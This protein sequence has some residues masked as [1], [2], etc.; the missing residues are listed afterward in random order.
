MASTMLFALFLLSVLTFYPPSITAQVTD[1][2]GNVVRNGGSFYIRPHI[3]SLG[4][5]I[6]RIKTGNETSRLSVV[7]SPFET[8]PG[9]PL[10]ITSP[11]RVQFI[12]EGPVF[13]DFVNDPLGVNS[14]EWKAVEVLSEGTLVKVGYQNSLKG[15]F[16]IERA[17]SA[18]TYK[19]LFCT[20]GGSLCGNVAIVNDE[21]G[22]RLLAVNQKTP[23]QFILTP[24]PST[25]LLGLNEPLSMKTR[26]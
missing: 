15:S 26:A 14:L 19:L 4:G 7:Q 24:L 12:P 6:R 8:D 10:K 13:I 25:S 9:L 22:N 1:G 3:F 18:N 11:Y 20:L 21:A 2:S 23:F 16:I 5:G 17:S